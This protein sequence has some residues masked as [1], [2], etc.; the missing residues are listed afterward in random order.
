MTMAEKSIAATNAE[1]A[2]SDAQ[3]FSE[4]KDSEETA[5]AD[6]LAK[7]Q[8][9]SAV[10]AAELATRRDAYILAVKV[11]FSTSLQTTGTIHVTGAPT[12]EVSDADAPA[13]G[14]TAAK[15]E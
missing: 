12:L 11:A 15:S 2:S 5:A 4:L 13:A 10:A 9:S 6:T 7:A 8:A 1:K 14:P 3:A